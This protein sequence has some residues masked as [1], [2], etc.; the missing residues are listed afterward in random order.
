MPKFITTIQLQ[1]ASEKDY[2][3]LSAE[4]AKESFKDE[5]HAAKSEAYITANDTFSREGDIT[6]Q[7]VNDAL[8]RAVSKTG[9]KYSFFVVRNKQFHYGTL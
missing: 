6:L 9:K 7:Q 4:L 2:A 8:F 3:T 5:K 1:D